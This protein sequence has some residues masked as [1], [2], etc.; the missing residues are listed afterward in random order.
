MDLMKS[1]IREHLE[2]VMGDGLW[3]EVRALGRMGGAKTVF[4]C[5]VDT[6]ED[7]VLALDND[8]SKSV[9]ISAN[10][11]NMDEVGKAMKRENVMKIQH[12][13]VDIDAHQGKAMSLMDAVKAAWEQ[14]LEVMDFLKGRGFA[15]RLVVN[16]GNGYHLWYKVDMEE[17][18][19]DAVR[20]FAR[21][22]TKRFSMVD[23]SCGEISRLYRVAGTI[24]RRGLCRQDWRKSYIIRERG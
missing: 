11:V 13:V 22:L 12:V 23:P 16:S 20:Q 4:G 24:N 5:R 1:D 21:G 8:W 17:S 15:D 6:L 9:S 19:A 18:G 14:A 3:Y 10:P 7:S 2:W